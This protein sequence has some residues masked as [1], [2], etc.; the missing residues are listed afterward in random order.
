MFVSIVPVFLVVLIVFV[1]AIFLLKNQ[2]GTPI[3]SNYMDKLKNIL[4][5]KNES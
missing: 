5:Q 1:A 3:I 4:F 2:G